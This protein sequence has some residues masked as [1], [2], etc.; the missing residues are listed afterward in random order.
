MS[1]QWHIMMAHPLAWMELF[2]PNTMS[3]RCPYCH[4]AVLL[5]DSIHDEFNV[6][7]LAK[8]FMFGSIVKSRNELDSVEDMVQRELV[9]YPYTR[10]DTFQE[11]FFTPLDMFDNGLEF[12]SSVTDAGACQVYSTKG[13]TK[14]QPNMK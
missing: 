14:A 10:R 3:L 7:S 12:T 9:K 2:N 4:Q 6:T 5:R 8:I 1:P 11:P 13:F